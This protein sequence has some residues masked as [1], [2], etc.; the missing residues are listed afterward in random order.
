MLRG[1][2]E[3]NNATSP[4]SVL[5]PSE[6]VNLTLQCYGLVSSLE[7]IWPNNFN[8][9]AFLVKNQEETENTWIERVDK[10]GTLRKVWT[11]TNENSEPHKTKGSVKNVNSK[12]VLEEWIS[13][14]HEKDSPLN[15]PATC[16]AC[17]A[18]T[19]GLQRYKK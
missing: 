10:L 5:L 19:G 14:L 17:R 1:R 9:K 4:G 8:K 11:E 15:I 12:F 7:W 16:Q 6:T 13:K 18:K 2:R 3:K